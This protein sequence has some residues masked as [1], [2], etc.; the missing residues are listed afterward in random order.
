MRQPYV[1]AT[2]AAGIRK[3]NWPVALPAASTPST[4]PRRA[5]NQRV[6]IVVTITSAVMP[7]ATAHGD[8]EASPHLPFFAVIVAATSRPAIS[9]TAETDQ[10]L[11]RGRG[12]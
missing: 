10:H 4:R 8:A 7:G 6:A 2:H 3:I 5:V 1:S 9:N 12:A 11:A